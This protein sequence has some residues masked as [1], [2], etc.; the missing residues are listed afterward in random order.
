[1]KKNKAKMD[2]GDELRPEYDFSK[3]KGAVRGKYYK[4]YR[5]G[6][7]LVRFT[8]V[9]VPTELVPEVQALISRAR[10]G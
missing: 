6:K 10:T 8:M 1:M 5:A 9:A 4:R 2:N 3:L 7:N